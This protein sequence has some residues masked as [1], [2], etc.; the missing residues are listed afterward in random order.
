MCWLGYIK[1]VDPGHVLPLIAAIQDADVL[2]VSFFLLGVDGGQHHH[3]IEVAFLEHLPHAVLHARVFHLEH[4]VELAPG[5][6]L[7]LQLL[8]PIKCAH[9]PALLQVI[10]RLRPHER[11]QVLAL[12]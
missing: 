3:S 6:G 8:P 7:A 9:P 12:V 5:A 2:Y 11:Q 4:E 10:H 1:S